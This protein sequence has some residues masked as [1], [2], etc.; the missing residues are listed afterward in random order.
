MGSS[1]GEEDISDWYLANYEELLRFTLSQTSN[2][3]DAED[4]A[5]VAIEEGLRRLRDD[6]EIPISQSWLRTVARRRLIDRWRRSEVARNAQR[7]VEGS[8]AHAVD[9]ADRV[10]S[11]VVL[12]RAFERLPQ[13]Q[14]DAL[15][16]RYAEDVPVS[17]VAERL[18]VSYKAA[19]SLLGR[20]RQEFRAL[21]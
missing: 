2:R 13:R 7:E 6:P 19:E 4:V 14:R 1:T 5:T 15:F 20:S 12:R 17:V 11:R 18:G 8:M 10:V 3:Q 16:I 21:L 9:V